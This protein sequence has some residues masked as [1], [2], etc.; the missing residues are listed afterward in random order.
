MSGWLP[1]TLSPLV[2]VSTLAVPAAAARAADTPPL[3][4]SADSVSVYKGETTRMRVWTDGVR[5]RTESE[6]GSSGRYSD[7][8]KGLAWSWDKSGCRQMPLQHAG[9]TSTRKEERLGGESVAG[10]PTDKV[11]VTWTS[12][13]EG[14]TSTDVEYEWRATDL[15]GLVIRTRNAD[16]TFEK[17]LQNIVLGTPDGKRL[18]FPSPPCEYDE[19]ADTTFDA[20]L[21][22][23][24]HRT[25]RFSDAGCKKL[26][27]LPLT[28]SIPSDYAIR[29]PGGGA[30][31][32]C[33]MGA[34]D[35]L[36]RVT[37][38]K[39]EVDFASIRRGVF[40]C[41]VSGSTEFNPVAGKF[42][43]ELGPEDQWAAGLKTMGVEKVAMSE[44]TVGG[45]ATL[46][47]TG[48]MA[49][50]K[51]YMLYLG[52]GDSPAILINYHP[53]GAGDASDEAEWRHFVDSLQVAK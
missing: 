20:P 35:D 34:V 32:G 38:S 31:A 7:K 3:A 51:V 12:S 9:L 25:I 10:H 52:V 33:L 40:W 2:A 49:G 15:R 5:S 43:S 6:D 13:Y 50:K 11:K 16:G 30:D 21:A 39:G 22:P 53:A 44:K 27:P 45:V 36:D 47:I 17:N 26:V 24:G 41:R 4:Y 1:R 42:V 8:G 37:A 48:V 14:K 23:G 29:S 46:R 19:M 18:A 28:L